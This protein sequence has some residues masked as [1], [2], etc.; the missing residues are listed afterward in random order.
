MHSRTSVPV[1][2][3]V[4]LLDSHQWFTLGAVTA[5]ALELTQRESW[6]VHRTLHNMDCRLSIARCTM[7]IVDCRSHVAQCRL[8]NVDCT[9]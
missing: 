4:Q 7:W 2:L 6:I 9:M 8:H 1:P 3:Q 5:H